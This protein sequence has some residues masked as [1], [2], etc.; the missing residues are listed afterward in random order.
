MS[1]PDG[2]PT[3]TYE[4]LEQW[5][6]EILEDYDIEPEIVTKFIDEVI[7]ELVEGLQLIVSEDD[8]E[9]ECVAPDEFIEMVQEDVLIKVKQEVKSPK[10]EYNVFIVGI[11]PTIVPKKGSPS[12]NIYA[13]VTDVEA[14]PEGKNKIK[15]IIRGYDEKLGKLKNLRPFQT[16]NCL[17]SYNEEEEEQEKSERTYYV[18]DSTEFKECDI[19]GF[20]SDEKSRKKLIQKNYLPVK[21][22]EIN[23]KKS[24]LSPNKDGTKQYPNQTDLKCVK[25]TVHSFGEGI[26]QNTGREFFV[27]NVT[28]KSIL[29]QEDATYTIWMDRAYALEQDC[30]KRSQVY[31]YGVN[32]FNAFNAECEMQGCTMIPT[33]KKF[34]MDGLKNTIKSQKYEESV[35]ESPDLDFSFSE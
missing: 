27:Y 3:E 30:G 11:Y 17:L 26:D 22:S 34:P 14:D 1:K 33:V 15:G 9:E 18:V 2:I 5:R 29:S 32:A 10:K 6:D 8:D 24:K 35:G 21:L 19:P 28:D 12:K 25:G 7:F 20:P 13:L 16:F 23:K 31:F 4:E